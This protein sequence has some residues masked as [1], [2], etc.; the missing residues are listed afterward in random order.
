MRAS[1]STPIPEYKR[2]P[3]S[4]RAAGGE[5]RVRGVLPQTLLY[6]SRGTALTPTLSR[7]R[8]RGGRETKADRRSPLPVVR[9]ARL[10]L[11]LIASACIPTAAWAHASEKGFVLLLPTGYYIAG[12]TLAVAASFLILLFLP[13]VAAERIVAARL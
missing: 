5:G 4:T 8:G 11:V 10:V 12:G 2:V 1:I 3:L 13:T 7:N 6:R 9:P